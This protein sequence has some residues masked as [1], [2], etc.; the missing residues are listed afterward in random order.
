MV[1]QYIDMNPPR[2][3]MHYQT[4]TPLPPHNIP[5]G[6]PRTP[7]PSM[8]YPASDIDWRFNSYMMVYMLECHSPKSSHPLRLPLSPKVRYTHLCL[9]SCLAYRVCSNPFH[10]HCDIDTFG[11]TI[12][13][14]QPASFFLFIYFQ[15]LL[16]WKLFSKVFDIL[17]SDLRLFPKKIHLGICLISSWVEAGEL[18]HHFLL[19]F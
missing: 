13:T 14:I 6:H 16:L 1:L 11:T 5:L 2:V 15:V 10:R 8:L 19:L 7:A 4:W 9:F 12:L 18:A 3:Y 17:H